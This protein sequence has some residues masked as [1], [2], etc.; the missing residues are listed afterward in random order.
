MMPKI[1]MKVGGQLRIRIFDG[2]L[3]GIMPS[4]GVQYAVTEIR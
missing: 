2:I 3:Y 4:K 1:L